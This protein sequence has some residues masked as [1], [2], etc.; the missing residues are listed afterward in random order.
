MTAL[1]APDLISL[2]QRD[3]RVAVTADVGNQRALG[4]HSIES[5]GARKNTLLAWSTD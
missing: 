5:S 1:L 4:T 2:L 3:A